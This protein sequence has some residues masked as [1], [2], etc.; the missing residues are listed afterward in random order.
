MKYIFS[1]LL[2]SCVEKN[3]KY[4]ATSYSMSIFYITHMC[5]LY[6]ITYV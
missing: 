1:V 4:M 3:K 6:P 2:L 5:H